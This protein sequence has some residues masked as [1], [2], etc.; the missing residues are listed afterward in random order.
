MKIRNCQTKIIIIV[1]VL[2]A[3]LTS[4]SLSIYFNN[5]VTSMS[6][7]DL[8]VIIK[9]NIDNAYYNYYPSG[10][11]DEASLIDVREANIAYS[12]KT[13]PRWERKEDW[14]ISD[15][16][17]N[18]EYKNKSSYISKIARVIYAYNSGQYVSNYKDA[19]WATMDIIRNRAEWCDSNGSEYFG[20]SCYEDVS[21][22]FMI[23]A[24][25]N[26]RFSNPVYYHT[27]T[28]EMNAWMY[29][30]W[31]AW[32]ASSESEPLGDILQSK[33]YCNCSASIV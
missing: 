4:V 14:L 23:G 11:Y 5:E 20:G 16:V 13:F 32:H 2:L 28:K 6:Y 24:D 15:L 19:M 17:S 30:I 33:D 26:I 10:G 12:K 21:L 18:T 31:L 9:S 7:V 25:E 27:D 8:P 3:L 22:K 29:S 1:C